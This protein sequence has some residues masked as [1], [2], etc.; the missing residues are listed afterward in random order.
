MDL[1]MPIMGGI[2]ATKQIREMDKDIPIVALTANAMVEDIKQTKDAGMNDHL[3]KPIDV[4]KIFAML[5][6]Y[7]NTKEINQ[8]ETSKDTQSTI[9]DFEHIDKQKGFSLIMNNE[10]IYKSILKG[11]LEYK[12][13]DFTDMDDKERYRILHTIK[14]VSGN[15]G[16]TTLYDIAFKLNENMD[17]TLIPEFLKELKI[18]TNEIE[19]K[20][21]F[22]SKSEQTLYITQD[23]RDKLFKK[24]EDALET[25]RPK[26]CIPVIEEIEKYKLN[27]E[28]SL[29]F[30]QIKDFIED[31]DL[32][33]A[34]E[35]IQK[36]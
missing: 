22:E 7:L 14:G 28:D 6:K 8:K 1:Q 29:I 10:K 5:Y 35:L 18:V 13:L 26:N 9:P 19:E 4:E 11:L 32:D 34:L 36:S 30:K 25:Q 21:E 24:L 33:E 20:M 23:L 15:A 31:Y 2:E 12:D 16:A 17:G 3:S 27:D